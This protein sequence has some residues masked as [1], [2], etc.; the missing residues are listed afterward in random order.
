VGKVLRRLL[1]RDHF[2]KVG[3]VLFDAGDL[4]WPGDEALVLD[5]RDVLSF[6]FGERFEGVLQFLF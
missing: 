4:F 6:G 3:D 1:V 2:A 5:S